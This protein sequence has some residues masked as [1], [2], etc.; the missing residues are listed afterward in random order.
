[1]KDDD[2]EEKLALQSHLKN[3]PHN[4]YLV[5]YKV[6]FLLQHRQITIALKMCVSVCAMYVVLVC[7]RCLIVIVCV[8]L[9]LLVLLCIAEYIHSYVCI[10]S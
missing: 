8:P 6:E 4:I 5:F 3:Q 7:R 9:H 2:D 10:G 1:M